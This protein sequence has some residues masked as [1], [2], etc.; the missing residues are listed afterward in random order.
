MFKQEKS[1]R[2]SGSRTLDESH[3]NGLTRK[4]GFSGSDA[5]PVEVETYKTPGISIAKSRGRTKADRRLIRRIV[6]IHLLYG[7]GVE[8]QEETVVRAPT[9]RE[10]L[11]RDIASVASTLQATGTP[12][13]GTDSAQC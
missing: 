6:P 7:L 10:S 5:T 13:A 1:S 2:T 11:S 9:I 12:A 8:M 3:P 4:I